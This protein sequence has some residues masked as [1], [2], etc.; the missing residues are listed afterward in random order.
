MKVVPLRLQP[1][2]DLRR[3]LE[4][5]MDAQQEQG[6]L[7]ERDIGNGQLGLAAAEFKSLARR[8]GEP[9]GLMG[10]EQQNVGVT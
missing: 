3:A 4:A 1:G 9:V 5:W 10:P 6:Q 2:N 8:G 7:P